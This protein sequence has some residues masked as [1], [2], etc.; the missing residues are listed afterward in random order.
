[1][2]KR[3]IAIAAMALLLALA[4]FA[5]EPAVTTAAPAPTP[6]TAVEAPA[7]ATMSCADCHEETVK[8]F[9]L[10]AHARGS[11]NKGVVTN[12]ACETCHEGAAAHM[13]AGGDKEKISI[14]RGRAGAEGT[15]LMCHD[16]ATDKRSHRTGVHAN[17]SAVNCFSCHSVHS[18]PAEARSL[19]KASTDAEV[20]ASCHSTQ[21]ASLRNKPFAHRV[22]RSALE[23]STCHEAHGRAGRNNL[24]L[25]SAGEMVCNNCHAEKRGPFVF[26]HGAASTGDCISCHEAHGSSN[27][28]Q[29]KRA[30]V[31]QLCLE[32]HSFTS[33]AAL[34]V[35]STPPAFHNISNA[36]YQNCTTCHVA[37]H[38]S[39]RSP[40]LLK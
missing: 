2:S 15:C 4:G 21:V 33:V 16:T 30:S 8:A 10:N 23:C 3:P 11:V 40:Q 1:M 32:C 38:G 5:Q 27:P 37:V 14:P 39:N 25:T 24:K 29:L 28:R 26:Q 34:T 6:E 7:E 22:G 9:G 36:R 19:L 31:S 12:D 20:C 35:G 18:S 13:E 17:S